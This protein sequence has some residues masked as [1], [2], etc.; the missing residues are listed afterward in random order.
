MVRLCLNCFAP[1]S[2][3]CHSARS[4]HLFLLYSL[5]PP[6]SS[7]DVPAGKKSWPISGAKKAYTLWW[8]K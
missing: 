1:L 6:I 5:P 2:G 4:L 8:G 3:P 7:R